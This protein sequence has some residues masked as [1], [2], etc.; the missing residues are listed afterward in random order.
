MKLIIFP[1]ILTNIK[2]NPT[3]WQ[4][5]QY[6]CFA[7]DFVIDWPGQG[8]RPGPGP[9]PGLVILAGTGIDPGTGINI[10]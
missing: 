6:A 1:F 8:L 4:K 5:F 9:G 10:K 7:D 2:G 3:H